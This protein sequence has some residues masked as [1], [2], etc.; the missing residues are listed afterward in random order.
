MNDLEKYFTEN[1][2]KAMD[3]WKHYFDI[4]DRYFSRYRGTDV[5]LLELGVWQGGSLQMWKHYFGPRAKIYGLDI[6]P[7]C[8]QLEEDQVQIFIG[9]QADK[10]FLKSVADAIPRLDILIDDGG[11]T[12]EQQINT[13]EALFDRIDK[14]GIYL[15]EDLHSSYWR[16]WGGGYKLKGTFIEYSK[17][18]I[19]YIH[20]WHSEDPRKLKVTDFT[21][22][23][24][25]LHF[26]DSILVIEKKPIEKP[27]H[28]KT[29]A[30]QLPFFK[31]PKKK[32]KPAILR[33]LKG[34]GA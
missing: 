28:F 9:D 23:A 22:S 21:R 30:E 10:P 6:N 4:Y 29:G 12:M 3:K 25:A 20:A 19:D 13:F 32:K 15:C 18:F 17:N 34:G 31:P 27:Y 2:G 11:H 24:Y 26:Y 8:K 7:Q 33:L 14:N 1:S 16:R 5:H